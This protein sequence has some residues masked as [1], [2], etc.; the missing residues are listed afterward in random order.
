ASRLVTIWS[1]RSNASFD[2]ETSSSPAPT[3]ARNRSAETTLSAPSH[4]SAH[5]VLPEPEGPTSTTRHGEGRRSTAQAWPIRACCE[6]ADQP[7]GPRQ[8][9]PPGR[10]A[11][12][13]GDRRRGDRGAAPPV[14]RV[15][16]SRTTAHRPGRLPRVLT[17]CDAQRGSYAGRRWLTM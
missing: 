5:V 16:E 1:S 15:D 10:R 4:V 14:D 8:V 2:A 7:R 9:G 3:T 13:S 11:P 17:G 12:R 6:R